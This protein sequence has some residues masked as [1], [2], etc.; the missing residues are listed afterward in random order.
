MIKYFDPADIRDSTSLEKINAITKSTLYETINA[1]R[2]HLLI[3]KDFIVNYKGVFYKSNNNIEFYPSMSAGEIAFIGLTPVTPDSLEFILLS[4]DSSLFD[5]AYLDNSQQV[6][7]SN[8]VLILPII[9]R[10]YGVLFGLVLREYYHVLNLK[11]MDGSKI[12]FTSFCSNE[13]LL[14]ATNLLRVPTLQLAGDIGTKDLIVD[15]KLPNSTYQNQMINVKSNVSVGFGVETPYEFWSDTTLSF[16]NFIPTASIMKATDNE[17][18]N[19]DTLKVVKTS[20]RKAGIKV[21]GELSNIA[22]KAEFRI[23]MLLYEINNLTGTANSGVI[24]SYWVKK[25]G[26]IVHSPTPTA[27]FPYTLAGQTVYFGFGFN[28]RF[29][30]T[31]EPGDTMELEA[32]VSDS[33]TSGGGQADGFALGVTPSFASGLIDSYGTQR[34]FYG[35]TSR[36]GNF[37]IGSKVY[38]NYYAYKIFEDLEYDLSGSYWY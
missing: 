11:S 26:T 13:P 6:Y 36:H 20:K 8:H 2:A 22:A 17:I 25:N 12:T 38:K 1:D 31:L 30:I 33:R 7:T 9:I 37:L 28:D 18:L 34:T 35:C 23:R 21:V 29:D 14:A 24:Y 5:G 15:T 32:E 16:N 3:T 27:F 4:I 19:M 10:N